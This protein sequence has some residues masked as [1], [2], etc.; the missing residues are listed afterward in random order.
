MPHCASEICCQCLVQLR[1]AIAFQ[2]AQHI[3]GQAFAVQPDNG[4]GRVAFANDQ[5]DMIGGI[6]IRAERNYL[7]IGIGSD[8]QTRA[9]GNLER[10]AIAERRRRHRA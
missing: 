5:G 7:R 9:G 4:R 8:R 2:A 3:A 10:A 1:P 6:G